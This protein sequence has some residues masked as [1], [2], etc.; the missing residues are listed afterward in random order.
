MKKNT[1]LND[2]ISFDGSFRT[3]I[4][5]YLCLNKSDKVN[6]YIP[7]KSSLHLL[8]DYLSS[9]LNKKEQASLLIGPY[10]KGKSH[11]LLVLLAILSM[12]RNP[13][14]NKTIT[15]LLRKVKST[16]EIGSLCAENIE[17]LWAQKRFLPV[18]ISNTSEDLRQAFLVGLND[19]LKREKLLELVPDTTF[20]NAV[21]RILD[22]KENYTETYDAF[23]KEVE[24]KGTSVSSLITELRR[25]SK[26]SME[27]FKSIYPRITA[28]STFNPLAV[29]DVLPIYKSV[30]EKLAEEYE[31]SGI[32]IVFDE[33]SKYIESQDGSTTGNNMKLLQ[34]I[35]ELTTEVDQSQICITM[36][37][38]KSIKEY[39]KYLS[40][41][42]I[43]SFTG[44]EGRIVEKYF[45]TST[46]NN[47]E[48][49]RNAIIKDTNDLTSN[50][51]AAR[52]LSEAA[53]NTYYQLPVFK[54][55]F[56]K[57]DFD[58]IIL[59]GCYPL[60]PLASFILLN[61]SEK[62]AQNERTLFT[63]VSNDEAH[64]LA[65]FVKEHSAESEWIVGADLVYDYFEPLFRKDVSNEY[66]HNIWLSADYALSKCKGD[67]EKRVIKS[68]ATV[69]IVNKE[70]EL[71]AIDKYIEL[72]ANVSDFPQ[73][74]ASLQREQI[75]YKKGSTGAYAFKTRA[76]SELKTEIK[77]RRAIKGENVNYSKVLLDVTG[78]YYVIPRKYNSKN[79]MTRYFSNEFMRVEDFLG[80][81]SSSAIMSDL[82]ADGKVITLFD[83][84]D[85][86][87]DT[88]KK[89]FKRIISDKI[90]IVCPQKGIDKRKQLGDYEIIQEL[91]EYQ[92]FGDNN[93]ILRSELPLLID[94][95]TLEIENAIEGTYDSSSCI[96]LYSKNNKMNTAY[97]AEEAVNECCESLYFK[98]PLVNNE[99]INRREIS[100]AQTRKSRLNIIRELIS[101][102]C[103]E[104]FYS[105]SNQE[106]TLF[107]SLFVC[108][109]LMEGKPS[110]ELDEILS[111]INH[112]IDNCSD[113]K[114]CL[115]ELIVRLTTAPYGMRLGLV[116]LFFAYVL[117][118]R[119]EDI[120]VY[121]SDK[122]VQLTPDVIVNMCEH[123][124]DYA[125]YVSKEDLQKEKYIKELNVLFGVDDNRNLSANRIKDIV[126]CMQRWFRALAQSSRNLVALNKYVPDEKVALAM[127][128][129]KRELQTVEFNP[130]E[131]LFV[132]LP[133]EFGTDS[134]EATFSAID[135]CKT[136][137]DDYFDWL[138]AETARTVYGVWNSKKKNSLHRVLREWYEKQSD[139]AK[140]GLYGGRITNFMS[141]IEKLDVFGDSE[142]A[143]KLVKA[144]S[145]VYLE[146][147]N[148][149]SMSEFINDLNSIKKEVESIADDRETGEC[150]L[151]FVG[152]NG[153]KIRKI[154]H[155]APESSGSVLRN[156]IEDAMDE[157]DDLSV[158]DRVS[159]LLEMIERIIK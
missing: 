57:K 156:V 20:G 33:F 78:K 39:G 101:G 159:I 26:E 99:L 16:D 117:S 1:N 152:R 2:L 137:Y 68:I 62:V 141:C 27:L 15:R 5:L 40:Q 66:I 143:T 115:R 106:A 54:S 14:N 83:F 37:A 25:F 142:V 92:A 4:N 154:Y 81:S 129:I 24:S 36:V 61:I 60:N 112:F 79:C 34:D 48:L 9:V 147:W 136:Y 44:I 91:K 22:W 149:D 97:S 46:K 111:L 98:S 108:T 12:E 31:F 49:I 122:E 113:T 3:A 21:E 82:E 109:G 67:D 74:I 19:A 51:Q 116:P 89:H 84:E 133:N 151:S 70:D 58:S 128:T 153:E 35:C 150:E 30:S 65:R 7:T 96:V 107:R 146:N 72:C 6:S 145:N 155:R 63:F 23:E 55:G 127:K 18:L 102:D 52:Y 13:S 157:F 86:N 140:Q 56:S 100:S 103:S 110:Q 8:N 135:E 10:G 93:E 59:R 73:V 47:Y 80:I 120:I 43:N 132:T 29:E 125:L 75:V 105:G 28:G 77:N 45:I 95:L 90:V 41:D 124:N 88:V 130:F 94:D 17:E 50:S 139:R 121:F 114:V 85:V 42:I 126:V 104:S 138:Q 148:D 144:V 76:G 118:K 134:L 71:P 87:Q 32:Y 64:S 11:L 131:L 69:L 119:R 123:S 53:S 158:N 38:H